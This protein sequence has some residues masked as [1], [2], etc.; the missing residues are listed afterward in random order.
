MSENGS[1]EG[2]YFEPERLGMS[3]EVSNQVYFPEPSK[4]KR[5]LLRNVREQQRAI[6]AGETTASVAQGKKWDWR[7]SWML[8]C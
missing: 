7:R 5:L 3:D 6:E 2:I 4:S 8:K 1:S